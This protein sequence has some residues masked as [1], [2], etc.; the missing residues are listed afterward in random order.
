MHFL[1]DVTDLKQS[2][3]ATLS[4]K[5]KSLTTVLD[6]VHFIVNLYSFPLPLH[7]QVNLS[8][9][10]VSYFSPLWQNNFQ[11]SPLFFC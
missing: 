2:V 5:G 1:C 6:E 4:V 8:Y 10:K 7:L 11:N 9:P 3:E